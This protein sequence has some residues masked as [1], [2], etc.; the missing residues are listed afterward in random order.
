MK[1]HVKI[2][3]V[4][5]LCLGSL[6]G[7]FSL[8][9]FVSALANTNASAAGAFVMIV[10]TVWFLRSGWGLWQLRQDKWLFALVT[11]VILMLVLNALLLFADGGK[12][13]ASTGQK[14]FHL[15]CMAIGLYTTVILL[16]P[17][18]KALFQN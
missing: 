9:A 14:I 3:A 6:T 11:G 18:G 10:P 5:Y 16:L 17:S 7:L 4:I 1:I 2:L 13:A 8:F 15:V 12:F